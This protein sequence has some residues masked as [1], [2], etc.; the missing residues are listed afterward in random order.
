MEHRFGGVPAYHTQHPSPTAKVN[1]PPCCCYASPSCQHLFPI[2]LLLLP[3]GQLPPS[4]LGGAAG[5]GPGLKTS[6]PSLRPCKQGRAAAPPWRCPRR[7]A[8]AAGAVRAIGMTHRPFPLSKHTGA[9]VGGLRTHLSQTP[10]E[11]GHIPCSF[12]NTKKVSYFKYNLRMLPG[13]GIC[14]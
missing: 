5:Q 9:D 8:E 13:T 10:P 14:L 2:C 6:P 4:L 3:P 12:I 1:R 11:L 7:L